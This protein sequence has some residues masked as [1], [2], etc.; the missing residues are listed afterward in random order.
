MNMPFRHLLKQDSRTAFAIALVVALVISFCI[1]DKVYDLAFQAG[2][3]IYRMTN[4]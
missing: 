2:Q 3:S 1:K 4:K